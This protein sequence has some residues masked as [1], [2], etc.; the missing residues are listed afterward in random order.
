MSYDDGSPSIGVQVKVYRLS[1][2]KNEWQDVDMPTDGWPLRRTDDRGLFRITGLP[3]GRYIVSARIPPDG[4]S[5]NAIS[6]GLTATKFSGHPGRLEVFFSDTVRQKSAVPIEVKSG[7]R[8]TGLDIHFDLTKLRIISGSVQAESDGHRLKEPT[9]EL[10]FAD[11]KSKFLVAHGDS[12]GDFQIPFVVDGEY[13]L[14]VSAAPEAETRP[15][16]VYKTVDMP[17]SVHSNMPDL[18]VLVPDATASA[19]NGPS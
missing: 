4:G 14:T 5:G 16:R 13:I 9:I 3:A 12:D 17:L 8:R 15:H 6:G 2:A 10:S 18:I 19:H 11:D 7:E 1:E